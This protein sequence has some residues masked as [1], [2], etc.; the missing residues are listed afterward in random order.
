MVQKV[1]SICLE[2]AVI[3]YLLVTFYLY[4]ES[5]ALHFLITR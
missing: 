3:N 2:L 1:E 5:G 4:F